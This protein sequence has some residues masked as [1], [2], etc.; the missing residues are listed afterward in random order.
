[1]TMA[2]A[3]ATPMTGILLAIGGSLVFSVNDVAIKFL[4]G[5][6]PLHQVVLVRAVIGL[7]FL[8]G[9]IATTG[10]HWGQLRTTRGGTHL[11]RA[12]VVI[13]SNATYFL[14]LAA[15]PLADAVALAFVS[16]VFITL[17]SIPML[18]ER[19]G[20]HRWAAVAVGLIGTAVMLRP[21]A[22][23]FQPAAVLVLISAACYAFSQMLARGMRETES[24]V[25]LSFYNQAGFLVSSAAMG[26]VAGDGRLA[27]SSDPSVQFLFRAWVWPP[28]A[29]WPAFAATGLAVAL[30]GLM[31]AQAYRTCEAAVV[32]PFEYSAIPMA[33]LW[34]AVVFG[35]MPDA[36]GL[37]GMALIVSAGL[38]TLWRETVRRKQG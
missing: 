33:I 8:A 29:D 27:G 36:V 21:G 4:S 20:P 19:V 15:L 26:L 35:T 1:M 37:A 30:G 7:A 25:T 16:P 24:A 23:A 32:A 3:R 2:P 28:V 18:G 22:G 11:L 34:G 13:A 31:M 14:A 5:D 10:G 12:L 6:Y 17:L 38:Y 9:V